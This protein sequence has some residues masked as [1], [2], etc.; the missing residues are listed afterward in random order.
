MENQTYD[1]DP[2][3]MRGR[4]LDIVSLCADYCFVCENAAEIEKEDFLDRMLTLLPRIYYEFFDLNP[5]IVS[6]EEF[7]FFS[8]YVDDNYYESIRRHIEGVMGEDDT[9]LETFEEDMKYSDQPIA[10]SIA[11]SLADLYQPLFNFISIVKDSEGEKL[12]D[13]FLNCK[14]EFASYWSQTLCNV[15]RAL[16]NIKFNN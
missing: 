14:E 2:E 6:L 13:A 15:M 8:S 4:L 1:F 16:N 11:E 5:D 10:A 3:K 7:D 12:T 9:F